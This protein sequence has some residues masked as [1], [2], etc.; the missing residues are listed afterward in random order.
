MI[1]SI[2]I[3]N[4]LSHKNTELDFS[5]GVNIIVGESDTGKSA[6]IRALRWVIFNR[7]VGD[8]FRSNW[9]GPTS[10]TIETSNGTLITRQKED[11]SNRYVLQQGQKKPKV[12]NAIKSEIPE[13]V[14]TALCLDEVNI[15][16]Q[17]DS[18]FL[19]SNSPGE[20]A[21][22][23]NKVAH[24]DKIDSSIAFLSKELREINSDMSSLN[25]QLQEDVQALEGFINIKSLEK[26]INKV[27]SLEIS[28]I[29][30]EVDSRDIESILSNV[31]KIEEEI[32]QYVHIVKA[33]KQINKLLEDYDLLMSKREQ[34]EDMFVL[35]E[36]YKSLVVDEKRYSKYLKAEAD[37]KEIA[38]KFKSVEILQENV[39]E[40]KERLLI[41]S[42]LERDIKAMEKDMKQNE[43]L[44]KENMGDTCPLCGSK[45]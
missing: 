13:E 3:Q 36:Q 29:Q 2:K 44:L 33:E 45:L 20:V 19:L 38:D 28:R 22:H 10:V 6:I 41:L 11:K 9:G 43:I 42:I 16:S 4:F 14:T 15:L 24:L 32:Q 5:P 23:F 40:I 34:G 1:Q 21:R 7:P 39:R 17:F 35:I 25:E 8:S 27:E 31:A 37:V 18:H 30:K 26:S 12:F